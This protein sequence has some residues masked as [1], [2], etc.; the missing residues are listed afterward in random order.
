MGRKIVYYSPRKVKRA[1]KKDGRN[2]RWKFIPPSWPFWETK[3]PDPPIGQT[4]P[5]QYE[6][7][8][9]SIAHENLERISGEWSRE[10]E[11]LASEYF[12]SKAEKEGLIAR[13][14]KEIQEH[15][16]T[17]KKYEPA[18][19]KLSEFAPRWIPGIVYW[20]I[21]IAIV[22]GEGLFNYF[23]F[24]IFGQDKVETYVMALAIVLIIPICSHLIGH[25]LKIKEKSST[26][27]FMI[28]ACSFVVFVLLVVLAI[29]RETFFEASDQ[30]LPIRPITITLILIGINLAIFVG[31]TFL[32]Y[33]ESRTD[34]E[35]Y[36]KAKR[37]LKEVEEDLRKE[38][39]DVERIFKELE[40]AEER[41]NRAYSKRKSMFERYQHRAEEERDTWVT[42]IREYRH[43]NMNARK[44]KTL[45]ES[46]KTDPET[47]IKIPAIFE[48]GLDWSCPGDEQKGEKE[49]TKG[50]PS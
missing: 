16:D 42:Y 33:S 47:L 13:H 49:V 28:S 26:D 31:L 10:D 6:S 17:M 1:G 8:L 23:V 14:Q 45:P 36:R 34:P 32:S 50:V 29:L 25:Y 20:P 44:D 30:A 46:F 35:G 38:G 11:G 27:K 18:R 24:Q 3:E 15:K 21:Y 5:S 48:N 43:G 9:I 19:Q 39:G 2:W 22:A 37:A 41:F 7:K 12:N 4:Q 40:R